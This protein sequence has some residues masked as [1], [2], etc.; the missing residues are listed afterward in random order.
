MKHNVIRIFSIIFLYLFFNSVVYSQEYPCTVIDVMGS[1]Y[2]DTMWLFTVEGT[3]DTYDTGWDGLK[4]FGS[5]L[6]PQIFA[7]GSDYNYQVYTS[8]DINNTVIGFIPGE[9]TT[10]TF[11]FTHYYVESRYPAIYLIDKVENRVENVITNKYQYRFN[12]TKNDIQNRFE[13]V[14]SYDFGNDTIDLK[15]DNPNKGKGFNNGK[16]RNLPRIFFSGDNL[17][18]DNGSGVEITIDLFDLYTGVKVGTYNVA[19]RAIRLIKTQIR[20]G[21]Y[22]VRCSNCIGNSSLVIMK[23]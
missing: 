8:S 21:A 17:I 23:Q 14:T 2:G 13:I 4:M 5:S 19:A 20:N 6:A 16:P 3:T 10:Y 11:T 15:P 18:V 9:D 1:R 12:S 22:L 7:A